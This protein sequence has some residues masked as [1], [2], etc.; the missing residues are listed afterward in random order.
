M[1]FG[2]INCSSNNSVLH[3]VQVIQNLTQC[4]CYRCFLFRSTVPRAKGY[5]DVWFQQGKTTL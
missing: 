4:I 5:E 1:V 2:F 3:T